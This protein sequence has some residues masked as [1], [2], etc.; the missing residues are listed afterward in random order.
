MKK[1]WLSIGSSMAA[2]FVVAQF[3]QPPPILSP[4]SN[5]GHNLLTDTK[6]PPKVHAILE[7]SC[8]DCHS[9][10]VDLPWYGHISPVSWY[11]AGHIR[12]GRKKLDFSD[13]PQ[14]DYGLRQNVA[15]AID[16]RSMPLR[17]YCWV[18]R[19]ATLS[20]TEIKV[21]EAWADTP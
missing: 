1:L 4:R 9:T 5:A 14:N 21:L 18:H 20:A 17:S 12:L 6:L 13:W 10:S 2:V 3:F 11:V 15:D 8:V 19:N 16:D 7:R